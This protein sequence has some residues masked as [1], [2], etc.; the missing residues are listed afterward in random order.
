MPPLRVSGRL[1]GG[2]G[3]VPEEP[4]VDRRKPGYEQATAEMHAAV[5]RA[6]RRGRLTHGDLAALRRIKDGDRPPSEDRVW[7]RL[8]QL[9]LVYVDESTSG[10]GTVELRFWMLTPAGE[11]CADL[12]F[13]PH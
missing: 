7:N 2:D 5:R 11:S 8:A 3:H 13:E 6:L 4:D 10:E 12:E 1:T 9:G